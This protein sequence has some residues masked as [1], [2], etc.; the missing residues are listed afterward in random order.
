M[1]QIPP[2][3]AFKKLIYL[4]AHLWV[5]LAEPPQQ[6]VLAPAAE[7]QLPVGAQAEPLPQAQEMGCL[8]FPW[9]LLL[10]WQVIYFMW[11]IIKTIALQNLF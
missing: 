7:L 5:P 4:L 3:P 9:E 8:I 11:P 2:A 6:Q 10:M 1:W